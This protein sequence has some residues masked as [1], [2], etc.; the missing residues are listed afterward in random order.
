MPFFDG[1]ISY[2][3]VLDLWFLLLCEEKR[4]SASPSVPLTE[5]PVLSPFDMSKMLLLKALG[6]SLFL[7]RALALPTTPA[8]DTGDI[9]AVPSDLPKSAAPTVPEARN[10]LED[11]SAIALAVTKADLLGDL[12]RKRSD[13][14]SVTKLRVRRE[15]WVT[16][17]VAILRQSW[18]LYMTSIRCLLLQL[19][20]A[21][22]GI[23][24]LEKHNLT[25]ME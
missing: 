12:K 22:F 4:K 11:L 9:T 15:W 20:S 5:L 1:H 16:T 23:N 10:Q 3:F 2:L 13:G 19:F 25:C 18:S 14:C 6:L 7:G 8:D 21:A 17:L 24:G